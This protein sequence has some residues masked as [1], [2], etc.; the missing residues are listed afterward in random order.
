MEITLKKK[1]FEKFLLESRMTGNCHVRFGGQG[2][3]LTPTDVIY[4][5]PWFH[6][7]GLIYDGPLVM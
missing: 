2:K 5:N 1:Y 6:C 3:S 4:W 7:L